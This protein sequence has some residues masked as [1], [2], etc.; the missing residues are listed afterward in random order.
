MYSL[1]AMSGH[2]FLP[3]GANPSCAISQP[4]DVDYGVMIYAV[5]EQ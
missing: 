3:R 1:I 4:R 2:L 5:D